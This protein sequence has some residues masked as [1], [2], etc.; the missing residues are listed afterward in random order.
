M[1]PFII[2]INILI[3][4]ICL[5][6]GTLQILLHRQ[7]DHPNLLIGAISSFLLCSINLVQFSLQSLSKP[8]TIWQI[9]VQ[10]SLGLFYIIIGIIININF[11]NQTI[12][13]ENIYNLVISTLF[14]ISVLLINTSFISTFMVYYNSLID[15]PIQNHDQFVDKIDSQNQANLLHLQVRNPVIKKISDRTL[16]DHEAVDIVSLIKKSNND[17]N[18]S[19]SENWMSLSVHL[20]KQ[21][22][23]ETRRETILIDMRQSFDR[24]DNRPE[25][26]EIDS[27]SQICEFED[28]RQSFDTIR[29][30][31][32]VNTP[33]KKSVKRSKSTS[34][35][36]DP[37]T[38]F[39][40]RQDRWKSIHDEKNF[41]STVNESL[42]PSVL[43]SGESPIMELKRKQSIIPEDQLSPTVGKRKASKR[44]MLNTTGVQEEPNGSNLSN[45]NISK[46]K[47]TTSEISS[48]CDNRKNSNSVIDR[49][50]LEHDFDDSDEENLPYINEFEEPID[51]SNFDTFDQ[52]F[53]NNEMSPSS[54]RD[55]NVYNIINGNITKQHIPKLTEKLNYRDELVGLETMPKSL[56][57]EKF[58]WNDND[59]SQRI[60]NISLEEWNSNNQLYEEK[61]SISGSNLILGLSG[62]NLNYSLDDYI[63][64]VIGKDLKYED[65]DNL[66][67]IPSENFIVDDISSAP[68]L[69][70]F[71]QISDSSKTSS[72]KFSETSGMNLNIDNIEV[73]QVFHHENSN[74]GEN[75]YEATPK[76]SSPIKKFFQTSP[77]RISS[78]LKR[79]AL[80][81]KSSIDEKRLSVEFAISKRHKHS[82]SEISNQTS[83]SSVM[84]SRSPSPKKSIISL[85]KNARS[86]H[87]KSLSVPSTT[88]A[89]TL[90]LSKPMVMEL[91]QAW[92]MD[93]VLTPNQSRASSVPSAVIGEYD[94]EKWRTLQA[95]HRNE[96]IMLTV[97]SFYS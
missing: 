33:K 9:I 64:P 88:L 60:R 58:T 57:S 6:I 26:N 46:S 76:S 80:L 50:N 93:S 63:L 48:P 53:L 66:S 90:S 85:V 3:F 81:T 23:L 59:E 2:G 84:S 83:F 55:K 20:K 37:L 8:V 62:K 10:L 12:F 42:L 40:K 29:L 97:N 73:N 17:E 41:M 74:I 24:L 92:E 94:R 96:E 52:S 21:T 47:T 89:S 4:A 16:V 71:R 15:Y 36:G 38:K 95:L 43:K 56:T 51:Q 91:H 1:A 31:G 14:I 70:T 45:V 13:V 19:S 78:V 28:F 54:R 68:S 39:K 79:K 22:Q 72:N 30:N 32:S 11:I 67:D 44:D 25:I 34:C 27:N 61:R 35:I 77:K 18:Y 82:N 5:V 75:I 7:L 69:H 87:K 49:I 65:I 86:S